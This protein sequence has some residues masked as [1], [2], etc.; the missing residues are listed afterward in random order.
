IATLIVWARSAALIPVVTPVRASMLTVNAVPSGGPFLP[1]ADIIGRS[2]R[3]T[4]SSSSV[5]QMRPRPCMAMKL[6]ASGVTASAAMQ[7]SPSFSRSSSSTRI[8][9]LPARMWSSAVLTRSNITES[10][11][12]RCGMGTLSSV[13]SCEAARSELRED[14]FIVV[15]I[16][17]VLFSPPL[18]AR[19]G[20]SRDFELTRH[21]AREHVDFNVDVCAGPRILEQSAANRVRDEHDVED[22]AARGGPPHGV[23]RE[24]DAVEADRAL[25]G[26]EALE[27]VGRA[28]L[29][30]RRGPHRD[31]G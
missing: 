8:T 28:H 19:S 23:E 30:A 6:M 17:L 29:E 16:G 24:A 5:R 26:E 7:R 2:R 9:I 15:D 21:V 4:C 3:A 25:G 18:A 10:I 1:G 20:A 14:T 27:L 12:S 22:D 31:D 13:T 11:V